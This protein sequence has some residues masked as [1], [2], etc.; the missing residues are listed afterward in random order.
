MRIRSIRTISAAGLL[1]VMLAV[2]AQ[3]PAARPAVTADQRIARWQ[4]MRFGMFI[5]WGPVSQKGTEIGWS[6]GAEIPE[7]QYDSLYLTFNPVKFNADEWVDIAKKAGMRYMILV[8]KHHDGFCEWGTR[9]TDYNI[10]KT[11]FGRD[12]VKELSAACRRAGIAFGLYY[13]ILDWHHPDYPTGS[14]GGK[15]KKPSPDMD[16]YNRYLKDQLHELVSRYGPF[17]TFWFDGQWEEPWTYERGADL[18]KYVRSL[19]PGILSNNRVGRPQGTPTGTTSQTIR[20]L[21]DYDT[22][23]QEIGRFTRE[24]P[25][26]SCITICEQWAWKPADTLKSLTQCVRTLIQCAGGDGNLLLNVGPMPTGEIEPR[27]VARLKEIGGWLSLYG[28]TIY[29][30]RGGPFKPGPWGAS[31]FR[32]DKVYLH[33]FSMPPGGLELPKIT[34]RILSAKPLTGGTVKRTPGERVVL[35]M[36]VKDLKEISTIIEL[37]LDGPAADVPPV[38]LPVKK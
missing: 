35:D 14:P 13:S 23:E 9:Y 30:T 34:R 36:P 18:Y 11:P 5:H 32:G 28:R 26:E 10:V 15:S 17:L 16:R 1:A 3:S 25:W 7:G 21:G 2:C 24:R 31:T 33:I 12:V 20:N 27:Q 37:T 8:S 19:Q 4:E 29:G 6:R 38:D 22:P